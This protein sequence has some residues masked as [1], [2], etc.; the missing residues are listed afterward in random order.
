MFGVLFLNML[1]LLFFTIII[2][3]PK[4]PSAVN[5]PF[6]ADWT[7]DRGRLPM[8]KNPFFF[9]QT[10]QADN[11]QASLS[12]LLLIV[13]KF[14]INAGKWLE[15]KVAGKTWGECRPGREWKHAFRASFN[16]LLLCL[17]NCLHVCLIKFQVIR[18]AWDIYIYL[19]L[20][21]IVCFDP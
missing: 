21:G 7:S 15:G 10:S 13:G 11:S 17:W 5:S 20:Q 4:L 2:C 6:S 16:T 18:L 8:A 19:V 14:Y 12:C 3:D 9:I 1:D